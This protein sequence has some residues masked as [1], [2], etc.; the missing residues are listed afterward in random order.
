MSWRVT[1]DV[2]EFFAKAG[3]Y[4][5]ADPV[6]NTLLLTI[7]N[8]ARG[9]AATSNRERLVRWADA[10]R[11]EAHEGGHPDVTAVVGDMA[12]IAPVYTPPEQRGK[13]YGGAVTVAMSQAAREAGAREVVL[14]TDLANP[15]SNALYQRL[16]YRPVSGRVVLFVG[17]G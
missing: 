10:F 8:G 5:R 7:A 13:G 14:F 3:D 2:G 9:S 16:G 11:R 4:L 1:A 12:R 6:E 15:T 17:A